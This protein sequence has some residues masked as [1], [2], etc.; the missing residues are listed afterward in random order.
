MSKES[1]FFKQEMQESCCINMKGKNRIYQF[2]FREDI[3]KNRSKRC[4]L[5]L[6]KFIKKLEK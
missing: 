6:K 4:Y 3:R 2:I 1:R 5:H